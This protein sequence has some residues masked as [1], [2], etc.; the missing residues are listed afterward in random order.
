MLYNSM[1]VGKWRML[2]LHNLN[3]IFHGSCDVIH[4]LPVQGSGVMYS[5]AAIAIQA[6]H[7]QN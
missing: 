5:Q 2:V 4:L 7:K 3:G 1:C 6:Y